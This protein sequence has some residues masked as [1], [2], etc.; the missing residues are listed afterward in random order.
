M[1]CV[2]REDSSL[3]N[4]SLCAVFDCAHYVNDVIGNGSS[5][6]RRLTVRNVTQRMLLVRKIFFHIKISFVMKIKDFID[7]VENLYLGWS[8]E[9]RDKKDF[10]EI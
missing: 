8:M 9:T 6:L 4:D 10:Q 5:V 2:V 7:A 1:V 3:F